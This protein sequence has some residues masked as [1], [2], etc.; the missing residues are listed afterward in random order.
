MERFLPRSRSARLVLR[1]VGAVVCFVIAALLSVLPGPA[2]V[3]WI[4]GF[5]LLGFSAGQILLS[6]HAVQEVLH[7]RVPYADRLPRLRKHQ[8]RRMLRHRWVRAIDRLSKRHERRVQRRKARAAE[9]AA[10][11]RR[12]AAG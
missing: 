3:F 6:V 10:Q 2:F 8:I 1:T 5:V 7:R 11:A 4:A 12:R 9:A